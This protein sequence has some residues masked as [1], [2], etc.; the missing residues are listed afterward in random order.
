M[1][2]KDLHSFNLALLAK[3]AWKILN[4][5]LSLLSRMYRGRYHRS[6]TFLESVSG[7]NPSYGWR[8]IQA[9]KT[10]LK[11]GLQVRL[12]NG[13]DTSVW[14]DHWLLE[15]PPRVAHRQL[16][17]ADMKVEELWKPGLR[18]WDEMKLASVLAP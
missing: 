17:Q 2:F 14:E 9:G 15:L 3:Q 18:E 1:R 5:P 10:L 11:K 12:G 8:S 6:S 4:N 16:Y 7:R 13:K